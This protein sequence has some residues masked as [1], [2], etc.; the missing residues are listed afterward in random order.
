MTWA[1]FVKRAYQAARDWGMQP[2]E[3]WALSPWEWWIELDA[4]IEASK[5]IEERIGEAKSGK[6]GGGFTNAEWAAARKKH[7]EKMKAMK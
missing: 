2:S 3:F 7:A 4:K 1:A 5:R 6:K